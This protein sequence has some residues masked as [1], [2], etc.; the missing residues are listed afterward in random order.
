MANK[1]IVGLVVLLAIIETLAA[2]ALPGGI[3][4]L[5]LVLLGLVY[6]WMSVDADDATGYLV[7]ALA[8]GA[9]GGA[10]VLGNIQAIGAPLD[11][12]VDQIGT[13]LYAGVVSVL[14]KTILGTLKG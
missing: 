6:G 5:L 14:A 11:G 9:A 2:G 1:I 4:G 3:V 12:I 7:L 8:V 10:D 13:A